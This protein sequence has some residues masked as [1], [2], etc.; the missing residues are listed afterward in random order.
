MK[1]RLL[2]IF[3][4]S[5]LSFSLTA[6][7][8]AQDPGFTAPREIRYVHAQDG[9][10]V[11]IIGIDASGQGLHL[12]EFSRTVDGGLNWSPGVITPEEVEPAMIFALSDEKAFVPVYK[13]SG[14]T[15]LPG[16]FV[17]YDGGTTWT[18]QTDIFTDPTAFPD[19]V[20]FFDT[21]NGVAIGDP[22]GDYFDIYTTPDGG[23]SWTKVSQASI[24]DPLTGEAAT[25]SNYGASGNSIWVP[26]TQGRMLFSSDMGYTW[27]ASVAPYPAMYTSFIDENQGVIMDHQSW[28]YTS[29]NETFDGGY[30]WSPITSSGPIL[31]WDI[32]FV[33]G[34]IG[35]FVSTGAYVLNGFSFSVNAGHNWHW[36]PES[37]GIKFFT[38]DWVDNHT[39]WAGGFNDGIQRAVMY[40]YTGPGLTDLIFSSISL[41]FGEVDQGETESRIVTVSNY[42]DEIVDLYSIYTDNM[43]F[44]SNSSAINLYPG[45]TADIEVVFQPSYLGL[46]EG[47]LIIESNHPELPYVE[48]LLSGTGVEEPDIF[49]SPPDFNFTLYSGET[50]YDDVSLTNNLPNTIDYEMSTGVESGLPLLGW[51]YSSTPLDADNGILDAAP[52]QAMFIKEI[53]VP[54]GFSAATLYLGFDDGCRV[55]VNG[56][57][58]L[59]YKYNDQWIQYWNST[60]DITYFLQEGRNRISVVVFN[61][62]YA[63][64]GSGGFDC[65]LTVDG[66]DLIKPGNQF[67]FSPEAMWYY[68]GQTGM[69]L[70]PPED[71][72]Q[73]EWWETDY[74]RYDWL[75]LARATGQQFVDLGWTYES[76]PCPG[77]LLNS[78]PDM[79]QFVKDVEIPEFT[80]ATLYLGFDDGCRIWINGEMIADYH[81]DDH[82]LNYWDATEMVTG[83]L[84]P[85][86]NRIAVEVYN[87]IWYGGGG[88]GFDCQLT[89]DGV[90]IIKR[91]DQ[92]PGVPEAMWYMFGAGGQQLIPSDDSQGNKWFTK[93]YAFLD[94]VPLTSLTGTIQPS[95][96]EMFKV[97]M[98][99]TG[100]SAGTYYT[101]INIEYDFLEMQTQVP[102][103][104]DIIDGPGCTVIPEVIDMGTVY[105]NWMD[106]ASFIIHNTGTQLL[107]IY[108]IF[109]SNYNITI[110]PDYF[111]L[112]P[113][114]MQPVKVYYNPDFND[115]YLVENIYIQSNDPVYPEKVIE[116]IAYGVPE[117]VLVIPG[118]DY[119]YS[120]L[121]PDGFETQNLHIENWGDENSVLDF[122]LPQAEPVKK[123][124]NLPV[125]PAFGF[126]L[127]NQS[128]NAPVIQR[129]NPDYYNKDIKSHKPLVTKI[130]QNKS[131]FSTPVDIF[132]DD[133]ESGVGNWSIENYRMTEAQWHLSGLNPYSPVKSWWCGNETTADYD[134]DSVVQEAI[135][136]PKIVLPHIETGIYIEFYEW[137]EVEDGYDQCFVDIS[138][139]GGYNWD[140]I[141]EGIPGS[142][143]GWITTTLD[144]SG[145]WGSEVNIRFMF[146]T[147][148]DIANNF[149]G[150]F[151][152]DV[153]VYFNDMDFLII[154]PE[155]GTIPGGQG[156]DISVSFDAA[157]YSPG[158]YTGFV[159]I[160]SNDPNQPQF[161]LPA[162]LEVAGS[163]ELELK[164]ALEGPY[165]FD[166][167][168]YMR[169]DLNPVLPLTQP[170]NVSPWNYT[171]TEA[172][173][174]IPNTDIVDWILLEFRDA[175][176]AS[177]ATPGTAIGKQAAFL[178]NNAMVVNLDGYSRLPIEYS[179]TQQLYVVVWHRNHLG[180][181]TADPVIPAGS[182]FSYDFTTGAAKAFG[183]DAQK[184][185]GDGFFGMYAGDLDANGAIELIDKTDTWETETGMN[186]YHQSDANM[187]KEV[188]NKDKNDYWLPNIG[189]SCQVPQ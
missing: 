95:E 39:G 69:L 169:T 91:G 23:D 31:N 141:R 130:T 24:P 114:Q 111:L 17:T 83:W 62:V 79:A 6:Q 11:W 122:T 28:N 80:D 152:D 86:R 120:L 2:S 93:D 34:T 119:L 70:M 135:I 117:P 131:G 158:F 48:I 26:T 96:W 171:G 179:I 82:G 176:D 162:Y 173:P 61:G 66:V 10:I 163:A 98:D 142:S 187:D 150:W 15:G 74:G 103:T 16:M 116:L 177:S 97:V 92:N 68:Y 167:S 75:K 128:S 27:N 38:T 121:P 54:S 58:A 102:V 9:Y 166:G 136:S 43:D 144:I 123:Q 105:L 76:T 153:Q 133:F 165:D 3:A 42:G 30:T 132:Y 188:N 113:G 125:K 108:G 44:Y 84:K 126:T 57:L 183:T 19:I 25:V 185:I 139:D 41:D 94:D 85:G 149:P 147:G 8:Y 134:N 159:L 154:S 140:R 22:V 20:H 181:M 145:Y 90:D 64:G 7:W 77:N 170:F 50:F 37:E 137:W 5:L 51:N 157:G 110:Q 45:Q 88:G 55:W 160:L 78:S 118:V 35:T 100:L 47:L 124:A 21:D 53:I 112:E 56:Q 129:T 1:T 59:D 29:L 186:G 178:R 67:P 164:V 46:A 127:Q 106:S 18:R 73:K 52:D 189:S 182:L 104:L 161:Y 155:G 4:G 40:R 184:D 148:D 168:V 172:V 175:P 151:V 99:A 36:A 138:T 32:D 89:V 49:V 146:D 156:F 13:S 81:Y 143:G 65:Q 33:P 12:A 72:N 60:D 174:S 180:I 115:K 101:S 109:S 71:I 14:W 87:G 63:G 107:D